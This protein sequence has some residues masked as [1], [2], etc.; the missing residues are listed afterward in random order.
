M[1]TAHDLKHGRTLKGCRWC[2]RQYH[3][4]QRE[5]YC[6][7]KCVT[8]HYAA[9]PAQAQEMHQCDEALIEGAKIVSVVGILA[10]LLGG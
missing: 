4:Y 6:S 3:G 1:Q 7:E 10:L 2:G 5:T 8:E 9:S